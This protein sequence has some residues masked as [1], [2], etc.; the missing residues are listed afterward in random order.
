M[1]TPQIELRSELLTIGSL[2]AADY[3]Y[4]VPTHQ[5][6]FSWTLSTGEEVKHLWNDIL[7]AMAEDRPEYFLGTMVVTEDREERTRS[8]IDGQQRLAT[9]TMMLAAMRS[10]YAAHNDD[11][12]SEVARYLGEKDRRTRI[13]E[14]RLTL[15]RTNAAIFQDLVLDNI[16]VDRLEEAKRDRTL[17]PSNQLLVRAAI[18]I[19][20]AVEERV[21]EAGQYDRFLLDLE[22]FIKDRLIV[23]L[24]AVG[25]E[26]DA[27]LIFETLNDRGLA[28]SISDLLKNYIYGRARTRLTVVQTQWEEM[29]LILGTQDATQ[30]LRHYWLSIYGVVR[31]RDLYRELRAKFASAQKVL[32]LMSELR[33]AADSYA[34]ISNVDHPI[35][36][37]QPT[38]VRNDLEAL[39]LFGLSQFRPLLLAALDRLEQ[40]QV[41]RLIRMIVA[42]SVRYSIIGSL[43]TGNL[44]RAYSD[45]A[46]EV[47][48]GKANTAAKVF[49]L[50]RTRVYPDD[51]GFASD[52]ASKTISKAKLARYLLTGIANECQ[53][54]QD[55]G[56]I[57][58]ERTN[59][60]EHIMPRTPS[61]YWLHAAGDDEAS[62][63]SYVDRLG[64]LTLIE[65]SANRAAGNAS[66]EIKKREAFG[67]SNIVIT[68]E[69]CGYDTWTA[70]QIE[71]RQ[72]RLARAAVTVWTFP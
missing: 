68:K 1:P 45:A 42:V 43:G 5:R 6:D 12:A 64:N 10:V 37:G 56:V 40:D 33:A 15:N 46:I 48:K 34:A 24:V 23:I 8:L 71:E 65:N 20:G 59:T 11:R 58:D 70:E 22:Y 36:R 57:Q 29:M 39:Q 7:E 31:E 17:A 19:R 55:L 16:A 14:P 41:A 27:Y 13:M 49:S 9:L 50:L 18:F 30:F 61:A 52:F 2:L 3:R 63:V 25:D 47:R 35:W 38:T 26:A 67:S 28:L 69:L 72:R 51:A 62:Y 4:V 60:L 44:E 54:Q 53:P 66:F 21:R 32:S